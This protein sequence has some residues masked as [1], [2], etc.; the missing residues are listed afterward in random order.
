MSNNN[1]LPSSSPSRPIDCRIIWRRIPPSPFLSALT[2]ELNHFCDVLD[3]TDN[4]P[5]HVRAACGMTRMF[6]VAPEE[7]RGIQAEMQGVDPSNMSTR[8]LE[9]CNLAMNLLN[10]V[11]DYFDTSIHSTVLVEWYNYIHEILVAV[12]FLEAN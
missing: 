8:E 7:S 3:A 10:N 9:T 11:N 1:S 4:L 12:N 2:V 5:G 6:L